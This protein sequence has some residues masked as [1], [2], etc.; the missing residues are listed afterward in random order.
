M[1]LKNAPGMKA[2]A[3]A[4]APVITEGTAQYFT[5]CYVYLNASI[6]L[7]SHRQIYVRQMWQ[8]KLK[9]SRKGTLIKGSMEGSQGPRFNVYPT[10]QLG[11]KLDL[12]I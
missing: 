1:D 4:A 2:E 11:L 7:S 5:T 6:L 3:I 9:G 8:S 10:F 12:D